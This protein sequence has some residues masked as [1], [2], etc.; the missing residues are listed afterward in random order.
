MKNAVFPW[1]K[2]A[3]LFLPGSANFQALFELEKSVFRA[4]PAIIVFMATEILT[5]K[6]LWTGKETIENPEILIEDGRI[7]SIVSREASDEETIAFPQA[8][9]GPSYFDVHF[10]GSAGFDVMEASPEALAA[11]GVFLAGQG[12]AN[13]L[14]TTVT[15][16]L[17]ATLKALD[18][19]AGLIEAPE[20]IAD[21]A[22]ARPIGIHLEGPFL[23][24]A[25]C[26]V[27]PKEHILK[28][29][30]A[31]FD[32][33]WEAA[34]GHVHLMTLAPEEPGAE[35]LIRHATAKGVRVS[36]GHTN[37]LAEDARRAIAAGARS[38]THTFNAMRP[39]DHREP[40][41]LG[42]VLTND[43]LY[44][45]LI[46]DGIHIA[47]AAV[48]L[49]WR[50]KGPER[51]LL[52][53]DAMSAAGMPDGEYSL[54][55]FAV[56]VVGGKAMARGVLAGS[57][58]TLARALENFLRFT[59]AKLEEGLGLLTRNP[60]AMVGLESKAGHIEVGGEANLVAVDATGKLLGSVVRGHFVQ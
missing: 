18:G 17:D 47:P 32:R 57:T 6:R 9:L 26:G 36:L 21:S 30:V 29:D 58:L 25:K 43:A 20:K 55:G 14:A 41:V 38:A 28:P 3:F 42:E 12:T 56:E 24:T 35:E 51:A 54:G 34:R 5:A 31:I 16:S 59:G 49:W 39:F 1:G 27:Q 8:T 22:V 19:L 60:A 7:A 50:A 37:G 33:M 13:Y 44:A 4:H 15:A 11:I 40:G 53:T 46:C 23:S 48:D 45:E 52:V 10:H 2:A